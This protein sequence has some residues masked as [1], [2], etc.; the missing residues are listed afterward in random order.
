VRKALATLPCVESSSIK[1]DLPT[2]EARFTV[3]P[4]TSCDVEAVKQVVKDAGFTVS[5]VKT[6][7]TDKSKS[8]AKPAEAPAPGK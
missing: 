3:K 5:A 6:P 1:V 2:K 8:D 4:D 7:E